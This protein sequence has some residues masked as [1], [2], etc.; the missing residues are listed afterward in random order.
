MVIIG[1]ELCGCEVHQSEGKVEIVYCS[2]HG[3]ADAMYEA[4]EAVDAY[5]SSPYPEN[6]AL[7][8]IA[9]DKLVEALALAERRRE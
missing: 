8:Q 5:L 1:R 4:L 7:K 9:A 3:A 6:M 2:K